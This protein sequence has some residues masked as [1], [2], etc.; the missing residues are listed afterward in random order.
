LRADREANI[1]KPDGFEITMICM[2]KYTVAL[3]KN[4]SGQKELEASS[5]LE[6]IT[7]LVNIISEAGEDLDAH[8]QTHSKVS[9]LAFLLPFNSCCISY[10]LSRQFGSSS[11]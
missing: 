3:K 1:P 9:L 2:M 4:R 6:W 7:F 11:L 10:F 8:I 5:A